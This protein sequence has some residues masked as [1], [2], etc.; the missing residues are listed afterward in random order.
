MRTPPQAIDLLALRAMPELADMLRRRLDRIVLRWQEI[1]ERYIPD[2][3]PLTAKQVRDS[4]PTVIERIAAALE[5]GKPQE[6]Y[7]LAEIGTAHGVARFQQHY[8]IEELIIEY[9]LLRRVIFDELLEAGGDRL[10]FL[11]AIPIDM[12]IDTALHRGVATFVHHLIDQLKAAAAAESKYLSFLSHDLRNNLNSVTLMLDMLSR[13]LIVMPEFSEEARDVE[14]LRQSIFETIEGMDRLLQ[15][16]RLRKHEVK[17]KL[18]PVNLH[19]ICADALAQVS[20]KAAA[21][22]LRLENKVPPHAAAHSDRELVMLVL[23][24]LLGNAVKFS[25]SGAISIDA[26]NQPLGWRIRVSDQGPGIPREQLGQLFEAFTR[27]ETFGQ[28][29]VGLGLAIASHAT[30]LLGSELTVESEP[31]RGSTF[32]FVLPPAKPHV[33]D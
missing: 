21:K 5:S 15:A 14:S 9:R 8:N 17:L 12:G 2:A 1:V 31:G 7:E 3:D 23:Q 19:N 33:A 22:G 27:G 10:S 29:G 4:I 24:N 32:S 13:T 30:R 20:R 25:S 18:G 6:T 11:D 16:E 28:P 26:V